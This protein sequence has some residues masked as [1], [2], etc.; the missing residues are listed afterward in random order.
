ME[1]SEQLLARA[2]DEAIAAAAAAGHSGS[3]ADELIS[4]RRAD[5]IRE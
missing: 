5:A 4:E 2:Q 1:E 3:V